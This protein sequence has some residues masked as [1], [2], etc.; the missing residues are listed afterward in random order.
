MAW[1][2]LLCLLA[3]CDA[4]RV[5]QSRFHH[6]VP[7]HSIR[8]MVEHCT[9]RYFEQPFDHFDPSNNDAFL[10][11]YFLND[12]FY[13]NDSNDGV[14]FFYLGNEGTYKGVVQGNFFIFVVPHAHRNKPERLCGTRALFF[15]Y[16]E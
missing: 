9:E 14:L 10:Q 11:R 6:A 8:S 5:V 1:P 15:W 3:F 16:V 7:V 13:D 4:T 12:D 2:L